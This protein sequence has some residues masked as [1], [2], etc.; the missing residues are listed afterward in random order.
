MVVAVVVTHVGPGDMLSECVASVVNAGGISAL[1][2]IDNSP[3]ALA[4]RTIADVDRGVTEV[5]V[6]ENRGFG[7]AVNAGVLAAERMVESGAQDPVEFYAVLND[8]VTVEPDWLEPLLADSA[9]DERIGGVQPK[10][11]LTGTDPVLINSVGVTLDPAGA[12]C[13]IG[14]REPNGPRFGRAADIPIFSGGAVLLSAPF[15]ADLGGFD[16]RYFLYYEDVDL[17][18]RGA[19]RGWRFRC[20]PDS[21][22]H[23][24]ASSTTKG[25]GDEVRRLQERNRVW[26]AFRFGSTSTIARALW[27]SVR[28]LRHEPRRIHARALTAGLAGAPRRLVERRQAARSSHRADGDATTDH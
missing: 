11:L 17:A 9:T 2:V 27:L 7:A 21:V 13:D 16:E 6:V 18:L 26:T 12:G 23:H 28:R 1:I 3:G 5:I 22:V 14:L 4:G 19:E 24:A 8:D 25:L 20:V 10:M 15:V